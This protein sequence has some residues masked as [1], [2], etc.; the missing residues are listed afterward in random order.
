MP[1][2]R[3]RFRSE[4]LLRAFQVLL[5]L[6]GLSSGYGYAEGVDRI[7]AIV[8]DEV[9]LESELQKRIEMVRQGMSGS[10]APTLSG[11]PLARQVLERLIL[12]KIQINLAEKSGLRIDDETLRQAVQQIAQKNNVTPEEL[13][14]SLRAEG[15]EYS[16][17]LEQIRGELAQQRLRA[18]QV[19]NQIKISD[20]EIE[21]W[22]KSR[23]QSAANPDAEFLLG[24]I[25]ISTPQAASPQALKVGKERADKL[26][27]ELKGGLDFKEAT[28]RSSD[29]SEAL[30]GGD[31]GWRKLSAM[32]TLFADLVPKM[33]KGD[34]E[35]PIRSPSGFHIIKLLDTR[36]GDAE[37]ITK[38]RVRHILIKPNELINNNDAKKKLDAIRTRIEAGD[39]FGDLARGN[40]DDKGSAVKG[41]DLGFVSP[42]ALV[43]EF[44]QAMIALDPHH[45]SQPVQSQFGWHLIE[46][47]ERQESDDT[48]ELLKKKAQDDIFN[49][50]VGEETEIWLRRIRDEAFV[51]IR[52]PELL[53]EGSQPPPDKTTEP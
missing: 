19:N 51:E 21:H 25:L 4:R 17:F 7:V 50:K 44:E 53:P 52:I 22:L 2:F 5:L 8:E 9:I 43:P 37:R 32:P 3:E 13:R 14:Q 27:E 35:G 29:S 10:D 41:G 47:L 45:L 26:I 30:K 20:R 48:Q 36:G 11:L 49:R 46:V 28:V 1:R 39:D 12:E 42:G 23:G 16:E 38:T 15:I 40:S 18:S 31:L 33:K 34:L 6:L 24:H